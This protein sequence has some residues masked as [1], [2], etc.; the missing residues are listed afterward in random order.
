MQIAAFEIIEFGDSLDEQLGIPST[1]PVNKNFDAI[2]LDSIYLLNNMGTLSMAYVLLLL[3][4][5]FTILLRVF[6]KLN[7]WIYW[8]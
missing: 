1:K 4:S 5:L 8:T 3:L 7:K 2:G 6:G